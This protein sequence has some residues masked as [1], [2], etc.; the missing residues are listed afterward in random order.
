MN[1]IVAV[2]VKLLF[3]ISL[4]QEVSIVMIMIGSVKQER[5]I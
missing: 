4:V 2:A 3:G 5:E 1:S